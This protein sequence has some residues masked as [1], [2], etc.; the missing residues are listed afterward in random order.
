MT[1]IKTASTFLSGCAVAFVCGALTADLRAQGGD[2]AIHV[3][4]AEDGVM[5]LASGTCPAGQSSL[6]L[7]R[8]GEEAEKPDEPK[9]PEDKSKLE[10]L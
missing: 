4:V 1:F 9:E 5:R 2:E 7:K 10:D 8:A 3:C 6:Q